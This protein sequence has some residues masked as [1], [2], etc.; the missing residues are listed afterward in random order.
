LSEKEAVM[1]FK[2]GERLYRSFAASNFQ[3][4][5]DALPEIQDGAGEERQSEPSYKVRGYYTVWDA[6]YE[7]YPAVPSVDWPAEYEQVS[8]TALEGTDIN[9]VIFQENHADSPLARI[10]NGSLKLG[11]DEHGA[12]CEAD[13]GGCQRGRDLYESIV[14]GLV[15]EMSFGFIIAD[16]EQGRGMVTTKDERG[17]YHTTITRIS[18]IFDVSAVSIPASPYTEISE[19]KCR[20]AAAAQIE[21]DR[22]AE[23]EQ[24]E[25]EQRA[26]DEAAEQERAAKELADKLALLR[27]RA[28]RISIN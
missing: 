26:A 8:R 21:A 27:L 12:W 15:V 19:L 10:R 16:D 3:P 18:K 24:R 25:A 6:E 11:T 5:S 28:R 9:D 2:P 14:N 13:L 4:I 1:P 17:N 22:K 23:Q 7:L 20:S